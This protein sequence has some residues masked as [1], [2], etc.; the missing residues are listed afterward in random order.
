MRE[1]NENQE[2]KDISR[3]QT[4]VPGS[5]IT[6][7]AKR[8]LVEPDYMQENG[9]QDQ[10]L[11]DPEE[12]RKKKLPA[13][14][15][16]P[17][18]KWTEDLEAGSPK[19]KL[20]VSPLNRIQEAETLTTPEED[21]RDRAVNTILNSNLPTSDK[22]GLLKQYRDDLPNI[23]MESSENNL[24]PE[25]DGAPVRV[26]RL[27]QE[28]TGM[29]HPDHF[30]EVGSTNEYIPREYQPSLTGRVDSFDDQIR[31]DLGLSEIGQCDKETGEVIAEQPDLL[32][33]DHRVESAMEKVPM[34]E[35]RNESH[36]PLEFLQPYELPEGCRMVD[37]AKVDMSEAL[38]MDD[39]NFWNH[40]GRTKEDYMD[41]ASNLPLVQKRLD[42]GEPLEKL[43][44]DPDVGA[45][46][47]QYYSP[48]HMIH[49]SEAEDGTP[50]YTGDGRHRIAAAKELGYSFPAQFD[51]PSGV[52]RD[53]VDVSVPDEPD[54]KRTSLRPSEEAILREMEDA[55][56]IDVPHIK[57]DIKEPERGTMHLPMDSGEFDGERGNSAFRP[58]NKDALDLMSQYGRDSVDYRDGVVDFS[59]FTRQNTPWGSLDCQV[60]IPHMTDQRQNPKWEFGNRPVGAGH[61]PNYDLGNFAQADNALLERFQQINPEA[62]LKDVQSFIKENNLTWH[63]CTD[64][65]TMQLVPTVIHDA[66]RHSGGV[67]EMKYRMAFG[68]VELPDK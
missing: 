21:P 27:G 16:V 58:N 47:K 38:G 41:L 19:E 59:P 25:E 10:E 57:P 18:E 26:L 24:V 34:F 46:A 61:D 12:D 7:E 4:E 56:E 11:R 60:E 14:D 33:K 67:S 35:A 30:D 43:I 20:D 42:N 49:L 5:E 66:C 8:K 9:R 36:E 51:T 32:E 31:N 50:E 15:D 45:T 48:D 54:W 28:E 1:F 65:K 39:P 17:P 40:H 44:H 22:I 55:G 6:P 52:L 3:E 2:L 53:A 23:Q 37:S 62:T 63:E 64:G 13:L 68:N 29:S